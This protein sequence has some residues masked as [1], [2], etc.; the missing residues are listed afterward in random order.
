MRNIVTATHSANLPEDAAG[1]A[2]D[3][4]CRVREQLVTDA[5]VRNCGPPT[6]W[7]VYWSSNIA[8]P[9]HVGESACRRSRID[10]EVEQ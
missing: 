5:M 3:K 7:K 1:K 4:V 9:T 10:P 8:P 6:S 2:G